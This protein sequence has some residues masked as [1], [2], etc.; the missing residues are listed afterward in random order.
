M[1]DARAARR[2][3]RLLQRHRVRVAEIEPLQSLG[4]DDRG[5]AVGREIHVVGVGDRHAGAGPAGLGVDRRQAAV[6]APP[7]VIG[8]PQGLQIPSRDDVLGKKP[9]RKAID[10]FA[11]RRVDHIDIVGPQIRHIDP[12][13]RARHGRAEHIGAGG[14]VEV[15]GIE[16]RRHPG[17]RLDRAR[18]RR[19][20]M[21]LPE[22][23]RQVRAGCFGATADCATCTIAAAA[24]HNR[25]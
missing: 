23:A 8:D 1:V 12:R 21:P 14:T 7:P 24:E 20:V 25:P 17:H 15:R 18:G 3:H 22:P 10:H 16:D 2:R 9:D 19:R 6:R 4:D 5:L 13:Q 11:G